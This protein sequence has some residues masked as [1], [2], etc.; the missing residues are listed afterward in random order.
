MQESRAVAEKPQDV[1]V[2]YDT[3]LS[4]FTAASRSPSCDSTDFVYRDIMIVRKLCVQNLKFVAS[5]VTVNDKLTAVDHVTIHPSIHLYLL[6]IF[7]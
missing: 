4:K 7:K 1:A 6:K 3:Y 2:K 5:P